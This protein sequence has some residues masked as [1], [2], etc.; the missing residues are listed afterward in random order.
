VCIRTAG[1]VFLAMSFVSGALIWRDFRLLGCGMH[2]SRVRL[3]LSR[4]AATRLMMACAADNIL[5]SLP[6][7]EERYKLTLEV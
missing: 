2:P 1:E 5:F 7:D 4:N 3:C 6:Y